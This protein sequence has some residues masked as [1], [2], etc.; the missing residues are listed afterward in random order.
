MDA[1]QQAKQA[2]GQ[3]AALLVTDGM[4]I[5][6]GTGSTTA[7]ALDAL[8]RRIRNDGL[9]V[10]GVPTSFAAERLAQEHGIPTTTLDG[11]PNLDLALDGADEV[12]VNFCLIKGR[13]GAHTRE[14][15][16]ATQ[17]ERFVVLI[18]PSKEV[19]C[20]GEAHPLPVEIV[21]MATR[22]VMDLLEWMGAVPELRMATAKDGPV[23]SDQGFWIVDACFPNGIS[24]PHAVSQR[25]HH[26]PGVLDHGLFLDLATDVLVGNPDGTV[27]HR[28][29]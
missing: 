8:G 17:A 18:D 13:G 4:R 3:Q 7:F 2:A 23:I 5:G 11:D 14:K 27:L 28:T 9:S 26:Q 25:L 12:D 24:D 15:I 6:L 1:T 10:A 19:A 21:P 16:I 29:R 22:P 20:L